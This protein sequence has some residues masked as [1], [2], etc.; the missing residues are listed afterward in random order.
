MI[1]AR[2]R[3]LHF[4][5]CASVV[6]LAWQAATIGSHAAAHCLFVV[7]CEQHA[8]FAKPSAASVHGT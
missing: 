4:F 1:A 7:G 3:F 2:Q 6:Q 8:T 5:G